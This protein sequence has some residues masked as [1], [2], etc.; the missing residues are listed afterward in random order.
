MPRVDK[1]FLQL[2]NI[3]SSASDVR[4]FESILLTASFDVR[5]VLNFFFVFFNLREYSPSPSRSPKYP[6]ALAAFCRR[7]DVNKYLTNSWF[8]RKN[9][10]TTDFFKGCLDVLLLEDEVEKIQKWIKQLHGADPVG[11]GA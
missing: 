4:I 11:V 1:Q 8:C 6:L 2:Y 3:L 7:L 10:F 9:C 5:N